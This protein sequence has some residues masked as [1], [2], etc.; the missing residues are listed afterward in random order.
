MVQDKCKRQL[1]TN[2]FLWFFTRTVSGEIASGSYKW[3]VL[4]IL[5]TWS[6]IRELV[7]AATLE[8]TEYDKSVEIK[9]Y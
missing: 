6:P 5:S 1:E 2:Y 7:F 9:L 3:F 4:V 8:Q